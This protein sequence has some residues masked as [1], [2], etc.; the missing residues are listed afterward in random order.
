[1][2]VS[3]PV[4]LYDV[5]TAANPSR[6][7]VTCV[8]AECAQDIATRL[9]GMRDRGEIDDDP[10]TA[11]AP[12]AATKLLTVDPGSSVVIKGYRID[13]EAVANAVDAQEKQGGAKSQTD[14]VPADAGEL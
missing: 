2:D 9:N 6:L 3:M 12:R 8:T 1:M 14:P 4:Y 13:V 11:A 7:V 10:F 5:T